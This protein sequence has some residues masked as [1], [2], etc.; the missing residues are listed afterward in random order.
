[1]GSVLACQCRWQTPKV[2]FFH[3]NK[4]NNDNTLKKLKY[5]NDLKAYRRNVS[6]VV[7]QCINELAITVAVWHTE[8]LEA[9]CKKKEQ[10]STSRGFEWC[11]QF[12]KEMT[13]IRQF[14]R[15]TITIIIGCSDSLTLVFLRM[16]RS[17]WLFLIRNS[18]CR[19]IVVSPPKIATSLL[20]LS[21]KLL[22]LSLWKLAKMNNYW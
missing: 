4:N 22:S 15:F 2:I 16:R 6:L 1:M 9:S 8:F 3:L 11:L 19:A 17:A 20:T 13:S 12:P 5:Y 10:Q 14:R 21:A 7:P 18:R